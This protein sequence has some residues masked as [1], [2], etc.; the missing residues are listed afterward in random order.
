M[1]YLFAFI[2]L[3]LLA[4]SAFF[5]AGILDKTVLKDS[6]FVPEI[7]VQADGS[8]DPVHHQESNSAVRQGHDIIVQRNLFKVETKKKEG[9]GKDSPGSKE[10]EKLEPTTLS[11]SLWGTVTGGADLYAVIEDKKSRLQALYQEGDSIQD[12]T[13]KKILKKEVILTY[14]GKDQV[15]EMEADSENA[16]GAKKPLEKQ[17]SGEKIK[18]QAPLPQQAQFQPPSGNAAEITANIKFRPFFTKGSPDGVMVFG[19][20]PDS[21]FNR[22]GLRNGDIVKD[23]NGT[24]VGSVEEASS[25]L[26]DMESASAARI[27]L[28]RSGE[29]KE[30]SYSSGRSSEEPGAPEETKEEKSS[31]LQEKL[32]VKTQAPDDIEPEKIENSEDKNKGEES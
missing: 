8:A 22:A 5:F 25:L 26:S 6:S 11:L 7:N 23:I 20:K 17:T 32:E 21:A 29:T 31:D 12:A 13:I 16:G 28:I 4:A 27:T 1:K 18:N 3:I 24:P 10:P 2:N 15:L 19:I 30:I 9:S 14:Q